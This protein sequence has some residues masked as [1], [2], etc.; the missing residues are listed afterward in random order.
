M[1]KNTKLPSVDIVELAADAREAYRACMHHAGEAVAH[2]LKTG[3]ILLAAKARA[4]H[5]EWL[6]F[7]EDAAIPQRT[8]RNMMLLAKSGIKSATVADLGGIV[9][10]LE[11]TSQQSYRDKL[12]E[13]CMGILKDAG[14][15]SPV[16]PAISAPA[17]DGVIH[18]PVLMAAY[19]GWLV[20][21][22][23]GDIRADC[24][25][26]ELV[27]NLVQACETRE[28]EERDLRALWR[29]SDAR[30]EEVLAQATARNIPANA[31]LLECAGDLACE[32]PPG[33]VENIAAQIR[34]SWREFQ[35]KAARENIEPWELALR[36]MDKQFGEQT[37]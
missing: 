29:M 15:H 30:F 7:L 36:Q 4:K 32:P 16:A 3:K 20:A 18:N 24:K 19:C 14:I 23:S 13:H 21:D 28:S 8:A 37:V 5:G 1:S 31:V 10:A 22:L 27:C 2:Y 9:K 6:P 34:Q 12:R 11:W 33:H 25:P 35:Q 26:Q 17:P